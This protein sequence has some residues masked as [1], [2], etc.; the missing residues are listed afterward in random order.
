MPGKCVV[1]CVWRRS[2]WA[3]LVSGRLSLVYYRCGD[4][5]VLNLRRL[6]F[7]PLEKRCSMVAELVRSF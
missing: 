6:V 4:S 2:Q 5:G 7:S 1:V 3:E